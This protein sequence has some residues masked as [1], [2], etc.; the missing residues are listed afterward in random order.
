MNRIAKAGVALGI[1]ACG[2]DARGRED[3]SMQKVKELELDRKSM[4]TKSTSLKKKSESLSTLITEKKAKSRRIPARLCSRGAKQEL[5]RAADDDQ[6]FFYNIEVLKKDMALQTKRSE[7]ASRRS[8]P[9][10]WLRPS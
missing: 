4:V 5:H 2:V 1:A 3:A 6:L 7:E 8:F 9:T 10:S